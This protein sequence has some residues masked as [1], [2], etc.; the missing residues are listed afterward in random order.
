MKK[1]VAVVLVVAL[2]LAT[3]VT[4]FAAQ[5]G[6]GGFRGG[7]EGAPRWGMQESGGIGMWGAGSNFFWDAD[8]N[9]LSRDAVVANLD[10]AVAD[11]TI[12]AAERDFLLERY[13]FCATSG[14]GAVGV[15]RGPIGGGAFCPWLNQ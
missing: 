9:F 12:T 5:P 10:N 4:A 3:S 2:M 8:G 11:G 14:G 7:A 6:G 1:M 13:D 15:R